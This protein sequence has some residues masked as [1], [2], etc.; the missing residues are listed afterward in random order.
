MILTFFTPGSDWGV[1]HWCK[2][3][4][5]PFQSRQ[6]YPADMISIY[7]R[8]VRG[9]KT[10]LADLVR[11][12][13]SCFPLGHTHLPHPSQKM[14][15]FRQLLYCTASPHDCLCPSGRVGGRITQLWRAGESS[16][17]WDELLGNHDGASAASCL[18]PGN[19]DLHLGGSSKPQ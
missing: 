13:H 14:L 1:R 6:K 2:Q 3:L 17:D 10:I 11:L 7:F 16:L 9:F 12:L 19:V 15:I 8:Q 5:H 18:D 4:L